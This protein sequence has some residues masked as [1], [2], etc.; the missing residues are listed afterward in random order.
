M[1]AFVASIVMRVV[2]LGLLCR[3]CLLAL[4]L[5]ICSV[6]SMHRPH[7]IKVEEKC[8]SNIAYRGSCHFM[9]INHV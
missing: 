2:T 1:D 6:A 9:H 5:P 4:P 8:V 3:A 7:P